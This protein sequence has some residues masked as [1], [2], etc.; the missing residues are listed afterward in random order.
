MHHYNVHSEPMV[1]LVF[2]LGD[3]RL[4]LFSTLASFGTA[5][6]VTMQKL[7]IEQYFPV[8]DITTAFFE[9]GYTKSMANA[10]KNEC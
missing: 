4:K 5:I 3:C 10:E 6:D 9:N 2:A 7:I 8:D 1:H